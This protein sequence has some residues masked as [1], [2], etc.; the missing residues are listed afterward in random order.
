MLSASPEQFN[1]L[2]RILELVTEHER[3]F[4]EQVGLH[5]MLGDLHLTTD[6]SVKLATA[7]P[8]SLTAVL[9]A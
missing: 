1:R 7:S 6:Q 4:R 8:C 9:D 3:V 2:E 5:G